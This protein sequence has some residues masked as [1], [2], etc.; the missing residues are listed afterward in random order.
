M[1]KLHKENGK[2]VGKNIYLLADTIMETSYTMAH[3]MNRKSKIQLIVDNMEITK[4]Q[5]N[6]EDNHYLNGVVTSCVAMNTWQT[7]WYSDLDVCENCLL[8]YFI[9][10]GNQ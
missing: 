5:L 1:I 3:M 7:G 4:E 2:E 6:K 10:W 9:S 8:E